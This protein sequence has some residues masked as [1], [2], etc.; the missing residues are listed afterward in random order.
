MD[1]DNQLSISIYK[2]DEFE[3]HFPQS[4][5]K[6]FIDE[7]KK[8]NKI[9]KYFDP[10][11]T[12]PDD[13]DDACRKP[14]VDNKIF[15][16]TS[17]IKTETIQDVNVQKY[18]VSCQ[19]DKW[20]IHC[21]LDAMDYITKQLKN[22]GCEYK[23]VKEYSITIYEYEKC[24]KQATAE[25]FILLNE[26][27]QDTD[28]PQDIDTYQDTL[29]HQFAEELKK[30]KINKENL[31]MTATLEQKNINLEFTLEQQ[32]IALNDEQ[33]LTLFSLY[34]QDGIEQYNKLIEDCKNLDEVKNDIAKALA[35][36]IER[37]DNQEQKNQLL[38]LLK[39]YHQSYLG[40][41]AHLDSL[42]TEVK[43]TKNELKDIAKVFNKKLNQLVPEDKLILLK[44]EKEERKLNKAKLKRQRRKERGIDAYLIGVACSVIDDGKEGGEKYIKKATEQAEEV[45]DKATKVVNKMDDSEELPDP[46]SEKGMKKVFKA[47]LP[48]KSRAKAKGFASIK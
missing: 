22:N 27:Y 8:V 42:K 37:D 16:P 32:L 45:L 20:I 9:Y 13:H 14:V 25:T 33:Y 26:P 1:E 36:L 18:E 39:E 11:L 38:A 30:R 19:D 41:D 6:L 24:S 10:Y 15:H 7:V 34:G 46:K 35:S 44:Q 31:T 47:S 43:D 40:K 48:K 28:A 2:V 12:S 17:G 5:E 23:E 3:H 4:L 21:P 29:A